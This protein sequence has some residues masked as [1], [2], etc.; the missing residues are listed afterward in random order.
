MAKKKN[1]IGVVEL[2]KTTPKKR[3]GRHAKHYSK[4]LPSRKSYRGQ[5]R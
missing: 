5:G 4:R 2:L 1:S 3:P